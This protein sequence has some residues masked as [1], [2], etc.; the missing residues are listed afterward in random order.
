M[1]SMFPKD[2]NFFE[3]FRRQAV[4]VRDGC[5]QLDEMVQKFDRSRT[6]GSSSASRAR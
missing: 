1:F 2:E 6:A 3:L 5:G 4:L